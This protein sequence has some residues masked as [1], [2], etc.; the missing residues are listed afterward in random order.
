[1]TLK[2]RPLISIDSLQRLLADYMSTAKQLWC[3]RPDCWLLRNRADEDI[4]VLKFLTQIYFN[5]QL[6]SDPAAIFFD[7]FPYFG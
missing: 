2:L 7:D 5:R 1:V 3:I 6:L 4:V